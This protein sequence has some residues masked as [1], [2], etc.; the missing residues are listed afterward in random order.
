MSYISRQKFITAQSSEKITL[1]HVN[2]KTRLYVFDD[3]DAPIYTKVTPYYVDGLKQDDIEL[4]KVFDIDDLV[5][6]TFYYDIET[7]TLSAWFIDD[8]VPNEIEVIVTYKFFFAD[9]TIQ[10]PH[11]LSDISYDVNYEGRIVTS[12]GY[13]HKIGID[14]SLISLVGEG[15]LQLK[16]QDGGLDGIFDTLIFENQDVVIYSWN[17]NLLPSDARVIYRGRVTN[18][19]FDG[20]DVKLKIKDQIFALLDAPN[21]SP[22]TEDDNVNKTVIGQFKRRVYGRVD[23][24]RCQST[25]QIADGIP[26]TGTVSLGADSDLLTG[27]GTLFF[28]EVVQG[29]TILVG[30][31]E[32]VVDEVLSNTSIRLSDEA[33]YGAI[34][35]IGYLVP[36]RGSILK[37]R[38][39]IAAGHTC[40][41]VT[42]TI[43]EVP[44][45]N[46]IIVDNTE[47][48]FPG[49]FIEF[50]DTLER[51]EI[52][53]VAPGNIVVLRQNMINKPD[54]GTFAV[55]RPIQEVF[56]GSRRVNAD[57]YT[58]NNTTDYCGLVFDTDV[59][60]NLSRSKNSKFSGTFTN[61]SRT[62]TITT[63]E[64]SLDEVFEPGDY[65]KPD[66]ITYSTFYKVVNVGLTSITLSIPF[67]D[68]NI[69]DTIE[70]KSIDYLND[71]SI[72]S[73]NIL[74]KTVNGTATGD[75]IQ[76]VAQVQ[77][78][79]LDDVNI[80]AINEQS[81]VDG[82]IDLNHLVSMA[83]PFDFD[84]KSLPT[85]KDIVD[86]LSKSVRSSLTLDNDLNI[87]YQGLNVYTGEQLV[88]IRDND[89]IDWDIKATNGKTFKTALTR[90]R[91]TDVDLGTLEAGNSLFTFDSEFVTRYI[92]T[93]KVDELNL[94]LYS[95]GDAEI[96]SHRHLYY[97][98][99]GTATLEL[100]TDLR[101]EDIEIGDVVIADL[102]RLYKRFG[103]ED[104]AKKMMLV[105][106]KNL[107]GERTIL[108]LSDLGNTFNSSSFITP[109]DAPEWTSADS[110][111]K[112]RYGYITDNQGIVNNEEDTA[113]VHLIS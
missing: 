65:V 68:P 52:K 28:T 30:T 37:N 113:G 66:D 90:Y 103:D 56:I 19:T 38:E 15:T 29:D 109:N 72:I 97:N 111:Q 40:A 22:Y 36:S 20:I 3:G 94:Y 31:Q 81:F 53:T 35:E 89:I 112:M 75:W 55:R 10:L 58:I 42:K 41:E 69:T 23:G 67:A 43:L 105:I 18:K 74:G 24:L 2:A 32:F 83:I 106:G 7:S 61:G 76:T 14:Q 39:F 99:L 95:D 4:T 91:F 50:T 93:N 77:R 87:K 71:D 27:A 47:G 12:P 107:T 26:L 13:K 79:L 8:A 25:D 82:A 62:V 86:R 98:R 44:Q 57:D 34:G 33:D 16:N 9:K 101:L 46:R 92:G 60:F 64:I 6:S 78:D 63:S 59:E 100:E 17:P 110:D 5:E 85:V 1:A 96:M 54:L 104:V 45:F 84:D 21:M 49:D 51:L 102:R 70:Y 108:E 73:V 48:L 88:V 11:D 80:T